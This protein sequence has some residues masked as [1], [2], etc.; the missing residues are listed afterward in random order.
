MC[1]K[2]LYVM[3][4]KT[5]LI[6]MALTVVEVVTSFSADVRA[7]EAKQPGLIGGQFGSEDFTNLQNLSRLSSLER[8]FSEDDDYGR[9]WSAKWFGFVVAPASGKITFGAE[10]D[11]AVQMRIAGKTVIESQKGT[12]TAS[13]TMVKGK[14]YPIEVTYVKEGQSYECYFKIQWSWAGREKISVP[15]ANLLHTTEQEQEWIQ[16]A[17]EAEEEDGDDDDDDD[18]DLGDGADLIGQSLGVPKD[19]DAAGRQDLAAERIDLSKAVIVASSAKTIH[20]KAAEMLRDEIEKRTRIG[21]DVASKM[22]GKDK[23]AI[24][25]GTAKELAKQSYRPGQFFAVPEKADAYAVWIDRSK[26]DAATVCLAGYDDRAVLYAAGRL[27]RELEMSRDRLELDVNL[28]VATAPKYPLRGHQVGYRPK[29]N[30]YDGW[31]I[32]IWEQYFRDMIAFGANAVE[33]VP[34]ESDDSDD[35][36]HFPKPKLEMMVAMSQLADDYGLDVWIWYPVVDDDDL[37]ERAI[38]RA[39]KVREAV[40]KKL[41]RI[42]AIFVP[43]GDPGE[44]YPDQLFALMERLK[45]VLNKYHPDAQ[46]WVSPQG[47][48]FEGDAPGYLK[49]F[50]EQMAK[51]PAWLDG[52]VFGPQVADNLRVLREK[53][54]EQYP[55]R[56]YPDITHCLDAQ[57]Q[58]PDWDPAFHVTLYREPINPRPMAYA[59]IFRDWDEY[60]CG[61]ITY[62]EGVNDDLNKFVWACLG[63][64]PEMDVE[65]ILRQY[66]RYFISGRYEERFA[67]GLLWLEKNWDGPLLT[68]VGVYETLRMFQAMEHRATPQEKLNWRFQLA[69]Y[70]AYYDA[71]TRRRLIYETELEER[72]MEVLLMAGDLGSL[73]A[74]DKAEAIL[75]EAETKKVG[76]AWRAR[77]FEL[78]EALFQS[79]RMQLSVKR[80][81]ARS[82]RRGGNLDLIDVPLNNNKELKKLFRKIRGLESESQRLAGIRVI[83]AERYKMKLEHDRDVILEGIQ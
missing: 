57:Y 33:F 36:P 65:E 9:Q 75:N 11:Q 60:T 23:A 29:T 68:N 3:N 69:L 53:L 79:I 16:K 50:Y 73:T 70:R 58:V 66:S 46:M 25:V 1:S 22:P 77:T 56:R 59:K 74:L 20:A 62:C 5:I 10:T 26:R 13:L 2:K 14:E 47:F 48:D 54:P 52:V 4:K 40:F 24:I 15:S 64:D 63:W 81:K 21:L 35:S 67:E 72:A 61:F 51:E 78:A 18:S 42:D 71:Y 34:P 12:G 39:L 17:E 44:V 41:P 6:V 31:T 27:L 43:G 32:K 83:T 76:T 37:D 28:R 80:Y 49:V 19:S 8:A 55:I 7:A 82:V 30:A 45:K 38:R